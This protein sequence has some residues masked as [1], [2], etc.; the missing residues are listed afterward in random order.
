[1][2]VPCNAPRADVAAVISGPVA[3]TV[4]ADQ[5]IHGRSQ[6]DAAKGDAEHDQNDDLHLSS[7]LSAPLTGYEQIEAIE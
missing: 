2:K 6:N 3:P 4:R 7:L 5:L 1:M